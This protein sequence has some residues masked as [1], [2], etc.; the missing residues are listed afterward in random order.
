MFRMF[1]PS[2]LMGPFQRPVS[3]SLLELALRQSSSE[4]G[5]RA[6]PGDLPLH[7]LPG[8]PHARPTRLESAAGAQEAQP[9][10]DPWG[11]CDVPWDRSRTS[12]WP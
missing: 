3:A 4:R 6:S 5:L 11:F 7:A 8:P 9:P 2:K 1:T 12:R 10:G